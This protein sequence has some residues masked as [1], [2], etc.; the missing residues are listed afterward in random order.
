MKIKFIL[1]IIMGALLIIL[2][3]KNMDSVTL[4]LFSKEMTLPLFFLIYIIFFLGFLTGVLYYMLHS[5]TSK[6]KD[7][8]SE[9]KKRFKLSKKEKEV[10][11]VP[12]QIEEK[13][14]GVFGKLKEK[15][16]KDET[17]ETF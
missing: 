6:K 11:A 10:A 1:L 15:L 3:V 4:H 7:K 8:L 12:A 2:S 16:E 13:K 17:D 14:I 5:S 9:S